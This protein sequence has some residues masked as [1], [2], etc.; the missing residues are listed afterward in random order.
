MDWNTSSLIHFACIGVAIPRLY[1]PQALQAFACDLNRRRGVTP[2]QAKCIKLDLGLKV[3]W[4]EIKTN[5]F[6]NV[7]LLHEG[8][9]RKSSFRSS[10]LSSIVEI[11]KPMSFKLLLQFSLHFLLSQF[12]RY[13][14]PVFDNFCVKK[15]DILVSS[16]MRCKWHIR[17]IDL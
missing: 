14:F 2:M 11:S 17:F 5:K 4:L 10:K 3:Q 7:E 1:K 6:N 12:C 16:W 8:D 13:N 9:F 15:A